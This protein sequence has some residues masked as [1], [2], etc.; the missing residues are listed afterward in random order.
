M[1]EIEKVDTKK[2]KP[3]F[4]FLV[5][6]S[7]FLGIYV[8]L[9]SPLGV[10][11]P[12]SQNVTVIIPP[13]TNTMGVA[14]QL[15]KEGALKNPWAFVLAQK[16]Y[17]PKKPLKAGEYAIQAKAT[18]LDIIRQMRLGK[19]V[20]RQITFPEGHTVNQIIK[21]IIENQSLTGD[22]QS[23]P[24]EGTLL[25]ETYHY[26]YGDSRQS[27]INRMSKAMNE[28]LH[29]LW[30]QKPA[31]SF[32]DTPENL[33]VL[34]SIVEKETGV[35]SERP[36][37]AGVYLNRLKIGMRLQADPTVVY[38]L[39][40]GQ[41]EL[42]RPLTFDDLKKQNPYNT[43]VIS[44]LPPSPIACPGKDSLKAVIFPKKTDA[45]YFVANGTGGHSFSTTFQEHQKHVKLWRSIQLKGQAQGQ[46]QG[47]QR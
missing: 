2:K 12:G 20:V 10:L 33:L 35:C 30:S 24:A 1:E 40:F 45:L 26:S 36:E 6:F 15:K 34:A 9:Y 8:F 47:N 41:E 29:S 25:P 5:F 22:I 43:Y 4:G 14:R 32:I 39:T 38:G 28:A 19:T 21:S 46:I 11:Y 31:D 18:P 27:I 44:G 13:K 37:I 17:F 16:L 7:F 23:I 3:F 42:G